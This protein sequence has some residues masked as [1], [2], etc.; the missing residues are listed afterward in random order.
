MSL[1]RKLQEWTKSHT[2]VKEETGQ[3]SGTAE[4]KKKEFSALC[5]KISLQY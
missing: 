2:K 5:L 1:N 4:T 3:K